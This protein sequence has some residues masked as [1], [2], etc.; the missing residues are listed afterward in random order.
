MNYLKLFKTT[1]AL[2]EGH[3]LLTSGRHSDCFIQCA[4]VL[5]HPDH[6]QTLCKA[7]AEKFLNRG[8]STVIGPAIGG[9]IVAYETARHLGARAIFAEKKDGELVLGRGFA[10]KK[11]EKVLVVEDVTTTGGSVKKVVRIVREHGAHPQAVA[12]LVDRSG[13]GITFDLPFESLVSINV[14]SFQ[15]ER[16]PLC[17]ENKPLTDPDYRKAQ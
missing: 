8:I 6:T 13:G 4:Q 17:K 5:Q 15:P 9:I 2:L 11:D 7:L 16:C 3:F 14:D 12:V 1:G 10:L